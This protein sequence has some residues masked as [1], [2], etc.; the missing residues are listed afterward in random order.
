MLKRE[1][2]KREERTSEGKN[3]VNEYDIQVATATQNTVLANTNTH[4]TLRK[5]AN[6]VGGNIL[7]KSTEKYSEKLTKTI[8]F[9]LNLARKLHTAY[10]L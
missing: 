10:S 7:Q 8:Q 9:T 6:T 5:L 3:D 1:R 4:F 2:E